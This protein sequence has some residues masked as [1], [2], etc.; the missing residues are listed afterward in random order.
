[1][2]WQEEYKKKLV[3][4]E[5]AVSMVKS[6]DRVDFP[7]DNSGG[8]VVISEALAARLGELE[9]VEIHVCTPGIDFG[10]FQP[11][12]EESFKVVVDGYIMT[13]QA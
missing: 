13:H 12:W 1:M 4:A 3:T 11:G 10:W 9:D 8:P 6:G 5:E 7:L 2:G